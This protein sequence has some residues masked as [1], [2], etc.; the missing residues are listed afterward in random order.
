MISKKMKEYVTGSSL[1]RAMFEDSQK[2]ASIYGTENVYDFSLGNPCFPPAGALKNAMI[3]ILN[4]EDQCAVHGYMNNAGHEAVRQSIAD[5]LNRRFGTE[6]SARNII[7]TVGAAGGINVTLK[8]LIDPGDEIIVFSPYFGEYDSYASNVSARLVEVQCRREDFMPDIDG[9]RQALTPRT[10]AVILNS[11]NNPTGVVYSEDIIRAIAGALREK[12]TEFGTAI[13]LFS[14]E[15]YRELVYGDVQVPYVTRY[16]ENTIVGYS[17]SK[18]LS[19]A[20]ER[21]GYLVIP[22]EAES[23]SDIIAAAA[24][25]NRILG[26]VNAPSLMQLAV[27]ACVDVEMDL[28]HYEDNRNI[29]YHG[30]SEIGYDCIKPEGAFYLFFKS[31]IDDDLEF[32][33]KAKEFRLVIVPGTAFHCPGYIR[34]AYCTSEETIGAALPQFK[35]LWDAVRH[36]EDTADA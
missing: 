1:I 20:G 28:K 9:L 21:I 33:E 22:E 2:L 34:L 10:K 4:M 8:T 6:F 5:S 27:G 23:S 16:Y 7:M 29:L 31:P 11:P 25:A 24:V 17:Y 12:Q 19:L 14:D 18:S 26:F 36:E 32:A 35:K 30:L 13:Y 15:P 3:E